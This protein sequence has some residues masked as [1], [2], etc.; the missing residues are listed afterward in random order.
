MS[1]KRF[2]PKH[3]RVAFY[4]SPFGDVLTEKNSAYP[5]SMLEATGVATKKSLVDTAA[6]IVLPARQTRT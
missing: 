1:L 4:G 2:D 3:P 5:A 6:V